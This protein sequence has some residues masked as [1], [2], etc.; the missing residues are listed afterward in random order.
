M[1]LEALW[2]FSALAP[3]SSKCYE[4]VSIKFFQEPVLSIRLRKARCDSDRTRYEN[5]SR[6]Y[7]ALTFRCQR[8]P[9]PSTKQARSLQ[10][11]SLKGSCDIV[12]EFFKYGVNMYVFLTSTQVSMKSTKG[13]YRILFQRGVYPSDDFHMVKKYGQTVLVTQDLA[14][15]NYLDRYV[16]DQ[17]SSC[18][19]P[20]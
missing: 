13:K 6:E 19:D 14:L 10:A 4:N 3:A 7:N 5:R 11:I 12:T 17:C 1:H 9:M 16:H 8:L 20:Y 18:V 15:E 2:D